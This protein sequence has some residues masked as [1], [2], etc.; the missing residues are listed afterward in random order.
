[1]PIEFQTSLDHDLVVTR[2]WGV[3][4]MD[5]WRDCFARY[6]GDAHYRPGRTELIDFA[7][8]ASIDAT[9]HSI[10]SALDTV[11]RQVPGLKVRTRTLMITPGEVVYGLARMYQTLAE[12]ADGIK[13][14]LYRQESE[15]LAALCLD[16]DSIDELLEKGGFLP[17]TPVDGVRF[18]RP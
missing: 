15:A 3:V 5:E 14:E 16:F 13:V 10:W 8:V 4:S 11:N 12:N 9:F 7:G 17:Y 18:G 1:M 2:W 6:V